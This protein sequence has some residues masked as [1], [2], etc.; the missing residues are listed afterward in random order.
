MDRIPTKLIVK[1]LM[2]V[3]Y[4]SWI[5]LSLTFVAVPDGVAVDVEV[6]VVEEEQTQPRLERVDRN[7]EQDPHDPPLLSRVR[8]VTE[9]LV[10]L[11]ERIQNQNTIH[12]LD[13]ERQFPG[14]IF[15]FATILNF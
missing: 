4:Q 13:L 9:V 14:H 15:Y 8:V 5:R 10:D 1:E 12:I 2:C 7:D 3:L 11:G 6:L